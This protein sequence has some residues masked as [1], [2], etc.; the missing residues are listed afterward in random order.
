META[1]LPVITSPQLAALGHVRHAFF[2]RQGG[3]SAGIYA[4]LNGGQGSSD[5]PALVQENRARMVAALGV[6]GP[7]VSVY[8]VHSPNVATVRE[9]WERG[10]A[11]KADAMVTDRPGI[12]LGIT[13]ADCGPVLFADREAGIIG[14]AHAGWRGAV[15]GVLAATVE[16]MVQLGAA[17]ARII[18][19]IGP[20]IR[21]PSYE[22]GPDFVARVAAAQ[23]GSERYFIASAGDR[24]RFDL[25]GFIRDRLADA[26]VGTIEDLGLDTYADDTRFFSYRRTTHRGEPDYGRLISAIALVR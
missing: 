9:P 16:A 14:A 22:V 3:A 10:T 8:Q 5:D 15:D 13:T 19:A 7:L 24:V 21:Q 20:V 6:A 25:P 12:A 17:R 18:A 4:S 26:G 23:A 1:P 11:P 2:T